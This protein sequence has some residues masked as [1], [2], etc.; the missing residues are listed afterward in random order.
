MPVIL[1]AA[2]LSTE[3]VVRVSVFSIA[4]ATTISSSVTEKNAGTSSDGDGDGAGTSGLLAAP[5]AAGAA[6]WWCGGGCGL[7]LASSF[8]RSIAAAAVRR[9]QIARG[10]RAVC[11]CR[12]ADSA[13]AQP[14]ALQ[15]TRPPS[16]DRALSTAQA[17]WR[18]ALAL[19]GC[20]GAAMSHAPLAACYAA[21]ASIQRAWARAPAPSLTE[22]LIGHSSSSSQSQREPSVASEE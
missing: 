20:V 7:Q 16:P 1:C 9:D 3:N 13:A 6:V 19:S 10:S 18:G 8:S 17:G 22:L 2:R 12:P 4:A 14:R 11:S 15:P 5:D 21:R